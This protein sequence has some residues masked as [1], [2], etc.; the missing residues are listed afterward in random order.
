MLL[1]NKRFTAK[2]VFIIITAFVLILSIILI[3]ETKTHYYVFLADDDTECIIN[4]VPYV[5]QENVLPTGC[6]SACAVMVLQYNG[7]DIELTDFAN[8]YLDKKE[9]V[10]DDK[11]KMHNASPYKYF[12]G[13]PNDYD[14]YGCY[15]PV[16]VNA[17]NKAV[18]STD[19]H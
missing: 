18:K 13:N 7:F 2:V 4:N 15:A 14:S 1:K 11:G 19:Y 10:Y 3:S 5:T 6:E 9:I 16:I 12:I 17:V 8:N